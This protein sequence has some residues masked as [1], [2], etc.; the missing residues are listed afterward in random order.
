M[1]KTYINGYPVTGSTS[2]ASAITYVDKDGNKSTVQEVLDEQNKNFEKLVNLVDQSKGNKITI[3]LNRILAY[4]TTN[5]NQLDYRVELPFYSPNKNY[6][7]TF[8][9]AIEIDNIGDMTNSV[10]V[11]KGTHY[12]ICRTDAE[13]QYQKVI[14]ITNGSITITFT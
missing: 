8:S 10:V 11:E 9:S 1:A 13:S 7:V 12:V 14:M 3:P 5:E 2:Y 6:N 4:N